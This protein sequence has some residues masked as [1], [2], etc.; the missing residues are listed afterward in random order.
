MGAGS[1]GA[2]LAARLSEESGVRVLVLEA[3]DD[4]CDSPLIDIPMA[5]SNL[6]HKD[7]DWG[8]HTVPQKHAG[9]ASTDKVRKTN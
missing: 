7:V 3:G 1:A 2:V 5:A 4:D 9:L 8:Y 6:W